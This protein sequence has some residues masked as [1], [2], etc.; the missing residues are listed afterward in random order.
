MLATILGFLGNMFAKV[1]SEVIKDVLNTPAKE[2]SIETVG[3][4]VDL[5]PTPVDDLLT[6]YGM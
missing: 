4:D 5:P 2:I 3:G 1:F 6:E